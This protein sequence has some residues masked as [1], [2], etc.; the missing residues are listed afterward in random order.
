MFSVKG[1]APKKGA[2]VK[3]G[4]TIN[5]HLPFAIVL[6]SSVLAVQ[7]S[8]QTFTDLHDFSGGGVDG[9][10]PLGRL[11]LSGRTL[12]GTTSF[13]GTENSIGTVFAINTDGSGYR[14]VHN[15][16]GPSLNPGI[17]PQGNLVSDGA[18]IYGVA[19]LGGLG[20]GTVF[21]VRTNGFGIGF[22][23]FGFNVLHGFEAPQHDFPYDN[24]NSEGGYPVWIGLSGNTLYGAAEAFG[25][26]SNG[27]VFAV[28]TDGSGFTTLHTFSGAAD[29][30]QP[31]GFTLASNVLY[32]T[33]AV[34][35]LSG[36]GT[37]F[38]LNTDGSGF[39]ILYDGGVPFRV[40]L[41][42]N[43]LY[44]VSAS[45]GRV[46]A[47]NIDGSGFKTLHDFDGD[48]PNSGVVVSGNTLYGTTASGTVF[49]LCTN[50]TDFTTL[51]T[52][53]GGNDLVLVEN[54]LYGTTPIGGMHDYGTVFSLSLPPRLTVTAAGPNVVVTWPTNFAGYTL[55]ATTNLGASAL[56][57]TNLP[58]PV[59]IDGQNTV[60]NPISAMQQFFRLSQ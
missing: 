8:A 17:H 43:T 31:L 12:Y 24:T 1:G 19:N 54:T 23:G 38:A 36:S 46:F 42:G 20:V 53:I 55:Q 41:S 26:M 2:V 33:T 18:T 13:G 11:L 52:G 6:L 40:T 37:V 3:R 15:F 49:S 57:T 29:G 34:G 25:T 7:V 39:R 32:G 60:T 27:T 22:N 10:N 44:V 14:I 47:L 56:W 4:S 28:N 50:G 35:G 9:D 51:Y 48:Y 16:G 21:S 59:V 58:A 45:P 5:P 30:G